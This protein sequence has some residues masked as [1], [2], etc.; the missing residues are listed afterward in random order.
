MIYQGCVIISY[1]D[2]ELYSWRY[3]N[4]IYTYLDCIICHLSLKL[5]CFIDEFNLYFHELPVSS[6]AFG[7]Q[8]FK[9]Y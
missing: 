5:L 4:F 8:V 3:V 9:K 1:Y 6:E 2:S 7:L